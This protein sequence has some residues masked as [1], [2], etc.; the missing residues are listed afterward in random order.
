[1]SNLVQ[2]E[3]EDDL[4]SDRQPQKPHILFSIKIKILLALGIAVI[5]LLGAY[6]LFGQKIKNI[7]NLGLP[8]INISKESPQENKVVMQQ[9]ANCDDVREVIEEGYLLYVACMGGVL[10]VDANSGEVRDQITMTQGLSGATTTSMIKE[11]NMLYIGTQ[12]GFTI[13][14]LVTRESKRVSVKEGLISGSNIELAKDG[15]DLWIGSFGGL[16]LYKIDTGVIQNF[17]REIVDNSTDYNAIKILV[18][19]QAIYSITV[20]N[21]ST[22]GGVARYDKT[23]QSW[24]RFG[25]GSFG[26]AGPYARVDLFHI[27]QVGERIFV[28]DGNNL[29]EGEGKSGTSWKRI[30]SIIAKIKEESGD[31]HAYIIRIAGGGSTLKVLISGRMYGYDPVASKTQM[32]YPNFTHGENVLANASLTGTVGNNN[33]VWI[34]PGLGNDQEQVLRWFNLSNFESGAINFKERPKIFNLIATIDGKPLVSSYDGVWEYSIDTR[35]F[36]KLPGFQDTPISGQFGGIQGQ[37]VFRPLDNTTKIFILNQSCGQGCAEPK[38]FLYDYI[39]GSI[40]PFTIPDNI[41]QK[42]KISNSQSYYALLVKNIDTATREILFAVEGKTDSFKLILD[43]GEWNEAISVK[44]KQSLSTLSV[45]N[46]SYILKGNGGKFKPTTCPDVAENQLYKWEIETGFPRNKLWQADKKTGERK[47]LNPPLAPEEYSPFG[48][49]DKFSITGMMFVYD[50]LWIGTNRG[51]VAYDPT[52]ETWML[53]SAK[54]G[55]ISNEVESFTVDKNAVWVGTH[56]G[57]LSAIPR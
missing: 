8:L 24:E 54:E 51:L 33:K 38:I 55:L 32:M 7:T 36:E 28:S 29:W 3:S 18:T 35:V 42:I 53:F 6:T 41:R 23:T 57:G 40:K 27:V 26:I 37:G 2:E 17:T 5:I 14:N 16:S 45:C 52:K 9:W 39:E 50:R 49:Q 11:G 31:Q 21:A 43:T 56:W 15:N 4:S 10:V 48:Q 25:P 20:A 30:D 13:F 47:Q 46:T 44:E 12:D 34:T 19:P 22:P 1:M